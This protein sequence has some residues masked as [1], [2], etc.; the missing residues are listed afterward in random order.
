MQHLCWAYR[1]ETF[2][3]GVERSPAHRRAIVLV[4]AGIMAGVGRWL[5]GLTTGGHGGEV[6]AAIWFH[7]GRMP[8]L[9]TLG[10]AVLSILVV[11]MG[12]S[13]GREGAAKQ[14]GAAIASRLFQ[15]E[16]LPPSQCR[17]LTACGA[18][19]GI[20]AIYHVP[21]GGAI[22]TLE[23]LL[24]ELAMPLV[25]P[26]LVASLLATG[27]A[28][29]LVPVEPA[30]HVPDYFLTPQHVAWAVIAGP[31]LGLTSVAYVRLIAWA[32]ARKP[33]GWRLVLTPVLA[34]AVLGTTAIVFPQ[35]LGTGKNVVQ[36]AFVRRPGGLAD[37][38]AGHSEAVGDCW[39]PR[40]WRAR[41]AVHA[42]HHF[43]LLA[44]RRAR[45]CMELVSGRRRRAAMPCSDRQ[46]YWP[47]RRTAL[48]RQSSCSWN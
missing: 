32:D 21:L 7:E 4:C 37:R 29:L 33:Q 10:R 1:T 25:L 17:L 43:W 31:L 24:G 36:L 14:T 45:V 35:L 18:G 23:V 6:S 40:Q 8:T 5:F 16:K 13:L 26:A 46:P 3:E 27:V 28:L 15:W 38:G 39:L 34:L 9:R 41:R 42:H 19:A 44:G 11:G 30:F 12:A 20:A 48:C 47:Q 22:F 2:L